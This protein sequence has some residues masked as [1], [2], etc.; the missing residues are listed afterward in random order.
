MHTV[1]KQPLHFDLVVYSS[2]PRPQ[3]RGPFMIIYMYFMLHCFVGI[4]F[5]NIA[6]SAPDS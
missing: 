3:G 2:A 1:S 6:T 5:W 4:L